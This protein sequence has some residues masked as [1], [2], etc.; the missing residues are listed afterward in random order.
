MAPSFL[1][2]AHLR[3]HYGA[4]RVDLL[5]DRTGAGEP[6]EGAVE[7]AILDAEG[8]VRS[9]LLT[10]FRPDQLP[11]SPDA[12]S[13]AIQRVVRAIAWENLHD[14][15]PQ[16]GDDVKRGTD[17]ALSELRALVRGTASALLAGEP[18]TDRSRPQVLAS[19]SERGTF[20]RAALDEVF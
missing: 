7:R 15:H 20:S 8:R 16:V 13:E 12:T 4:A 1:S 3:D 10:R 2:E 19:K 11:T 18:A 5:A 9:E 14:L 6:T 17:L